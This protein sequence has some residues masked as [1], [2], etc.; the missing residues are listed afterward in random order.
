MEGDVED[1]VGGV[2]LAVMSNEPGVGGVDKNGKGE[3]ASVPAR[4]GEKTTRRGKE[5][6]NERAPSR[7]VL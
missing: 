5:A 7:F 3:R 6:R 2:E 1:D 4:K